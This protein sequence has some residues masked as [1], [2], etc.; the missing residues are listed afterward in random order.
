LGAEAGALVAGL[1]AG[2]AGFGAFFAGAAAGDLGA[3]AGALVPPVPDDFG[4]CFAPGLELAPLGDELAALGAAPAEFDFPAGLELDGAPLA[5]VD[6]P[7]VGFEAPG[8]FL[9]AP[10]LELPVLCF[11]AALDP[12][13]GAF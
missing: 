6:P 9:A 2:A 1:A 10:E 12:L 11:G 13:P 8:D 3:D 5:E 4:D 7:F